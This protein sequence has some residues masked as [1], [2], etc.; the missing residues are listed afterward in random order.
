LVWREREKDAAKENFQCFLIEL[1]LL[2]VASYL[3]KPQGEK[4]RI[5]RIVV[6]VFVAVAVAVAVGLV[7]VIDIERV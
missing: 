7:V 4:K 5:L 2:L 3:L 1:L 6:F